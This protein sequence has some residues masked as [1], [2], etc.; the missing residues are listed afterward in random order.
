MLESKR[1]WARKKRAADK[2]EAKKAEA[3]AA[4]AS[5]DVIAA[6]GAGSPCSGDE[7][8]SPAL[9]R[10]SALPAV[11]P[12]VAPALATIAKPEEFVLPSAL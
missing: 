11:S 9:G 12:P 5:A 4:G 1:R 2:I 8:N 3:A 6:I 10:G 7:E